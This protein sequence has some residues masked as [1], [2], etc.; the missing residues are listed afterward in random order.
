[1]QVNARQGIFASTMNID[2]RKTLVHSLRLKKVLL[3][4]QKLG[5]YGSQIWQAL[6][7]FGGQPGKVFNLQDMATG[8][9]NSL[10][11]LVPSAKISAGGR[12]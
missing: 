11:Q 9:C 12:R 1:M 2:S 3:S 5:A 4:T 7:Y 6:N 8:S 10:G